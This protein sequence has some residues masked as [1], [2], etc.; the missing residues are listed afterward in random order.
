MAWYQGPSRITVTA[1]EGPWPQRAVVTVRGA[2]PVEI[3][4]AV[5][6]VHVVD[7]ASWQ[8]DLE[9]CHEGEWSPNIRAV[10]GRWQ[11]I[12]GV[13]TQQVHSRNRDRGGDRQDRNLVLRIERVEPGGRTP[14]T[15]PGLPS[16]RR[17]STATSTPTPAVRTT[18]AGGPAATTAG[19][20]ARTTTS[21]AGSDVPQPAAPSRPSTSTGSTGARTTT[22]WGG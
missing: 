9:H 2:A 12:R 4:A 18:T 19:P 11:E 14:A 17:T 8:L 20:G 13:Q 15:T 21:T 7:A 22:S 6:A 3:P 16:S 5:G 1:V 10:Q